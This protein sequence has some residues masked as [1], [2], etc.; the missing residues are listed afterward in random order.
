M[1]TSAP[2]AV[3]HML[4]RLRPLNRA[5]RHAVERQA[6]AAARLKR[7]DAKAICITDDQVVN[8]LAD[9]E[10]QAGDTGEEEPERGVRAEAYELTAREREEEEELRAQAAEA[11]VELPL[12]MLTRRLHLS[13]FEQEAVLLCAAVEVDRAYERIF[14]Y[15]LDDLNR[16]FPCVELICSLTA[17]SLAHGLT[18]RHAVGR[19][20][21][22]R[23][24]GLLVA[25]GEAATE[26][27]EEF[28]LGPGL[29]DFLVG[30][31][32]DSLGLFRDHAAVA[33]HAETLLPPALSA[34]AVRRLGR[35]MRDG[36]VTALGVWGPHHSG[37]DEV[38]AATAEAAGLPLRR[39]TASDLTRHAAEESARA[40]R[41][42]VQTAAV[43]GSMLWV[44]TDTFDEPRHKHLFETLAEAIASSRLP[45]CLTGTHPWRPLRLL[46][47]GGFT[48]IELAAPDYRTRREMWERA[49]P[50]LG[51][52]QAG[53]LASRYRLS[54]AEIRS[55]VELARTRARIR[56][57]ERAHAAAAEL[58]AACAVVT[59]R[60]SHHFATE[61]NP[62][63]GLDDL[64]L[65]KDIHRQVTEVATFFRAGARVDEDWGFGRLTSGGGG[66]KAL[67]AGESGTGKTLAAEVIAG[68]LGLPLLK[69]DLARVVS[70]WVGETEKNLETVFREAEESHCV[71][72][73]DEADSLFGK[74]AE[75]SHG[76][77]RYA[78]LEVGYLL[79]RLEGYYGLVILA[80][81]LKEHIDSAFTRRFQVIIHFPLPGPEERQ[82]IWRIAI[83]DG[84]PLDP[85]V[86]LD[87]LKDLT[88]TGAGIVSAARTAALLA[89]DAGAAEI[90]M[91]HIVRGIARQYQREARI[92]R[93]TELGPCAALLSE[94]E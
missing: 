28:R 91:S 1:N 53:D 2:T 93:P 32:A 11:G 17:S 24:A 73:F 56:G 90:T 9:V 20:G 62:R 34:D 36:H 75:V 84:A 81:N 68:L 44:E 5:L 78:N 22:L 25:H 86:D 89:A 69:V 3:A 67:F 42:A 58:A 19:F 15:I 46:E 37:R 29:F 54:A 51:A 41:E 48:E 23:R 18:R 55:T 40:L 38:V 4:L 77:D 50:G 60:H 92:L 70:K 26:S 88:L 45:A 30:A 52:A 71:L 10:A 33:T 57:S 47:N 64:V 87:V 12:D 80:S 74:R 82:R 49:L 35:A 6:R 63:R 79:Q 43:L 13:P 31:S 7:P 59:R 72:F 39:L 14:A 76:T 61:V 85:N 66:I 83:P 16:L 94:V 21:R 65:P 27:R 8:L